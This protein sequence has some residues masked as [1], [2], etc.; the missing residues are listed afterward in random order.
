[1]ASAHEVCPYCEKELHFV[2][3]RGRSTHVGICR[4]KE[5][6]L[7]HAS[8]RAAEEDLQLAAAKRRRTEAASEEQTG[9]LAAAGARSGVVASAASPQLNATDHGWLRVF[10]ERHDISIS[11]L[12]AIL[13]VCALPDPTR[14]NSG[15]AFMTFVDS[16]PGPSFHSISLKLPEQRIVYEY[17]FRSILDVV[18]HMCVRHNGSLL[19]PEQPLAER[20]LDLID[21]ERFRR[22]NDALQHAAGPSATLA[23]LIF[24]SGSL[25]DV[26]LRGHVLPWLT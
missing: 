9:P 10:L 7:R 14:F 17:P 25:D 19:D 16:L 12:D 15:I 2:T 13:P 24:S 4:S 6:K 21:G 26:C 1:M 5:A 20:E 8:A 3:D 18:E 23:P 22:L 11:L